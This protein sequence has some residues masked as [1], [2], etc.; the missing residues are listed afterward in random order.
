[1]SRKKI[2]LPL[3]KRH[4]HRQALALLAI[5]YF[6]RQDYPDKELVIIDDGTDRVADL[7]PADPRIRYFGLPGR[8]STGAK[9]NLACKHSTGTL[10]AHWDDDDWYAPSRLREQISPLLSA[11]ADLTG[12]ANSYL[13]E[14]PAGR[15]WRTRAELHRRM[16]TGDVHGGTLVYWKRLL[17]ERLRYPAINLAEDAVFILAALRAQKRLLRLPNDG[18]FVY[19]RHGRNAWQFQPGQFLD[20]AGWELV[21]SPLGFSTERLAAYQNAASVPAATRPS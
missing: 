8:A 6:L 3:I 20:P 15:F 12:L 17:S 14:L 18:V 1:M 11:K 16:F 9:R 21:Q 7:I 10:I 5:R 2:L 13:L 19:V 4:T